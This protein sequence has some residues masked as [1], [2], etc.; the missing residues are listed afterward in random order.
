MFLQ[1]PVASWFDDMSDTELRDLVPFFEKLSKVDNIY[2]VLRNANNYTPSPTH[3]TISC[4]PPNPNPGSS[5]SH[6]SSV[7]NNPVSSIIHQVSQPSTNT[8]IMSSGNNS[9]NTPPINTC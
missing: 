7:A 9:S 4:T 1:V 8:I 3:I 2:N 6:P 5:P